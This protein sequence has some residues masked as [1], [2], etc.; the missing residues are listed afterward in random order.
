M[1]WLLLIFFEPWA[2]LVLF[3][4]FG[5]RQLP[6]LRRLQITRSLTHMQIEAVRFQD[7]PNIVHPELGPQ[8][9]STVRIAEKLGQFPIL[10]GNRVDML[11]DTQQVIDRLIVDIDAATDHVHLL[12]YI[13]CDDETGNR[14]LDALGRAAERGV[15]CRVLVDSLGSRKWLR[16]LA[17]K[18]AAR[19]IQLH[20][21][22]PI[23]LYYRLRRKMARI[24]VRNHR[25]LAVIDGQI[26]YAGSQNIVN[27]DYGHKDL[28]WHDLMARLT[29]PIT[30]ELQMIFAADWYQE[31]NEMLTG[32]NIFVAPNPT[33]RVSAQTLPSGPSFAVENYQRLVVSAIHNAQHRVIITT[34]YFVPDEPLLQAIQIAVWRGVQVDLIVP[35]RS[36]QV[37]VGLAARGY[38]QDL[39]EA[40]AQ[41]HLH[42]RGLLHSKTMTVDNSIALLGSSNFDV[43]SFAINF[44]LNMLLYGRD[45]TERLRHLQVGYL[46]DS[47]HLNAEQ[48]SRRSVVR[49]TLEDMARLMSPLL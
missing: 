41:V 36:D 5:S 38:Y 33:G 17:T 8:L 11:A 9:D 16:G 23:S 35:Q 37:I 47:E 19:G 49:R 42:T 26:A 4:L 32:P 6:R 25:K 1:A 3:S 15:T 45:V 34:P 7:D 18:M 40:G 28:A 21:M 48:W 2:G 29:G 31:S 13:F 39:L 12:F 10:G 43:R 30:I 14:V 27:A 46:A 44:E 24:D 22:L 20:T